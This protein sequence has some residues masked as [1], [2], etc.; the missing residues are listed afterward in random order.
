[1][2]GRRRTPN[3]VA[4]DVEHTTTAVQRCLDALGG[5][6]RATPGRPRIPLPAGGWNRVKDLPSAPT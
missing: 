5:G 2:T 6:S 3:G 4:R 1:M